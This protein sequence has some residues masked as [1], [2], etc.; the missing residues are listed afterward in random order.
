MQAK[1][2]E[3]AQKGYAARKTCELFG[4]IGFKEAGFPKWLPRIEGPR[5]P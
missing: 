5:S 4:E 2:F 1:N 3:W